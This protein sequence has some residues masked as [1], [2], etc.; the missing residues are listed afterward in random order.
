MNSTVVG[1]GTKID[2][3]VHL[4]HN[5]EVGEDCFL[6]AQVGVAGSTKIGNH[7]ILAGQAGITGH[8][9]IVDNVILGGKTGVI[10]NITEPGEYVGYPARPHKEWSRSQVLVGHLSE[11]RKKLRQLE[12]TIQ[13][14]KEEQ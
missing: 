2:N 12:K 3:L 13:Q 10:G 6:C 5:V 4:G 11:M 14:L 7:C 8:I 9:H 1:R